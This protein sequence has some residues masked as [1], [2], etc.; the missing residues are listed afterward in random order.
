MLFPS[1]SDPRCLTVVV[2]VQPTLVASHHGEGTSIIQLLSDH[3]ADT[4]SFERIPTPPWEKVN[5]TV[6]AEVPEGFLLA[7]LAKED[8]RTQMDVIGFDVET[9]VVQEAAEVS[10]DDQTQDTFRAANED[11]SIDIGTKKLLFEVFTKCLFQ[12]LQSV[13]FFY[14]GIEEQP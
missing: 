13:N 9:D 6:S 4:E 12:N 10:L 14:I 11:E 5:F 8:E 7:S 2:E 3:L 1:M